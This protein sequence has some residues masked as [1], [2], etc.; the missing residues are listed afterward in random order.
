MRAR[1]LASRLVVVSV[2]QRDRSRKIYKVGAKLVEVRV[3][4]DELGRVHGRSN[5]DNE[6]L[7]IARR[8]AMKVGVHV[9]DEVVLELNSEKVEGLQSDPEWQRVQAGRDRRNF[10]N[11]VAKLV[12]VRGMLDEV[13]EVHGRSDKDNEHLEIARRY[14]MKASALVLSDVIWEL[15]MEHLERLH[16]D[17]EWR[18][19]EAK[20][21]REAMRE[22][23]GNRGCRVAQDVRGSG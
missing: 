23:G 20:S 5:T 9:L 6:H 8:H 14:A 18:R 1:T 21:I 16:A 4:L 13:C 19:A 12:E 17:P 7:D 3:M 2:R 10:D 15:N 22:I 11:L